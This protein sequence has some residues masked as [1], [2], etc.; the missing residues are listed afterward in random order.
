MTIYFSTPYSLTT[1]E[2]KP[3]F[4]GTYRSEKQN[5]IQKALCLMLLSTFNF[6]SSALS[7]YAKPIFNIGAG[8]CH[9]GAS[10][11]SNTRLCRDRRY[12][13]SSRRCLHRRTSS[14]TDPSIVAVLYFDLGFSTKHQM[15]R[16]GYTWADG[17]KG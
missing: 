4:G 2:R 9:A 3:Q 1:P 6:L 17:P 11:P 5:Q 13:R 12:F 15:K 7:K 16:T 10:F 8:F 14:R